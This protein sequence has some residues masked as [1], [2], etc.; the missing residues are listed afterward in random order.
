MCCKFFLVLLVKLDG[1]T[2]SSAVLSVFV[3]GEEDAGAAGL[4]WALLSLSAATE[5]WVH[6]LN[7]GLLLDAVVGEGGLGVAEDSTVGDHVTG[8]GDHGLKLGNSG[9]LGDLQGLDG[10]ALHENLHASFF[11][12]KF[13]LRL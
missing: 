8:F 1:Q 9:G 2:A 11:F 4:L 6:D 5:H 3:V 7:G 12:C 13:D 10:L